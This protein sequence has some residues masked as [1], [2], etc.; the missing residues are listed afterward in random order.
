M[1]KARF[2]ALAVIIAAGP[3]Q[4]QDLVPLPPPR[5]WTGFHA[6]LNAGYALSES[7]SVYQLSTPSYIAPPPFVTPGGTIIAYTLWSNANG[8]ATA[9]SE[10]F[11]GG[12]QFGYDRQIWPGVVAGV[13][14]D[15][16]GVAG[17]NGVSAAARLTPMPSPPTVPGAVVLSS[18]S[19]AKSVDWIGTLR[20]R[21]GY[22]VTPDLLAYATGGLAYGG[23]EAV[24]SAFE[25]RNSPV[26]PPFA[27]GRF[28]DVRLGW[29]VG[30]G[31]EWMFA[32]NWSA[33][34]E[35][36]Y[37]DLGPASWDVG[38][39]SAVLLP[40]LPQPPGGV[41]SISWSRASTRFDGHIV[42][43]GL[44][45][46]FD[47]AAVQSHPLSDL[48]LTEKSRRFAPA[49]AFRRVMS[50]T[51]PRRRTV[52]RSTSP[53]N[54]LRLHGLDPAVKRRHHVALRFCCVVIH[55]F[56]YCAIGTRRQRDV[57]PDARSGSAVLFQGG[58]NV[59]DVS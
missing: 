39:L 19:A 40:P 37:Y 54:L 31:L 36:L 16:Q 46:H 56:L 23:A 7:D 18:L 24:A 4:A 35:Y 30:G 33:K 38:A 25:A 28:S 9:R 1:T 10:G 29:T 42:R 53:M 20:A 43:A 57:R 58:D 3:S 13:E 59:E 34:V 8:A 2:A 21:L 48:A 6:G 5:S 50:R 11:I 51:E 27:S 15:M 55:F 17:T 14:T 12:G 32:R 41:G 26:V 44:N 45:Y 52:R 47:W 49:F 22:L